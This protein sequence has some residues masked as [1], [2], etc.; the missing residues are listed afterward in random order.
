VAVSRQRVNV[1]PERETDSLSASGAKVKIEWRYTSSPPI[2]L[3]GVDREDYL[4][5]HAVWAGMFTAS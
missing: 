3:D 4:F 1:E 5:N 2:C